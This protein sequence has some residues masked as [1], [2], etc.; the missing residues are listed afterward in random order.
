MSDLATPYSLFYVS[1]GAIIIK[2]EQ[3]YLVQ[4]KSGP[5]KG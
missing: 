1:C 5:R 4:E 2:N 3:I